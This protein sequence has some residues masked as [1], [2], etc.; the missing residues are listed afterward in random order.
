MGLLALGL[1]VDTIGQPLIQQV[2]NL[3]SGTWRQLVLGGEQLVGAGVPPAGALTLRRC[4]GSGCHDTFSIQ[5]GASF[6][7]STAVNPEMEATANDVRGP[8]R[9][10]DEDS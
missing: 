7:D 4:C 1:K 10:M 6:N 2:T 8:L 5:V 3:G 9:T